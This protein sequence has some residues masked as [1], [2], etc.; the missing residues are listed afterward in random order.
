[1]TRSE[2]DSLRLT[3]LQPQ[4]FQRRRTFEKVSS[5]QGH[6]VT[7]LTKHTLL[8]TP[9]VGSKNLYSMYS[10]EPTSCQVESCGNGT[11]EDDTLS[12]C[13]SEKSFVTSQSHSIADSSDSSVEPNGRLSIEMHETPQA[14]SKDIIQDDLCLERASLAIY[15]GLQH[16]SEDRASTNLYHEEKGSQ[17]PAIR[18]IPGRR[19]AAT[20]IHGLS[21]LTFSSYSQEE[22]FP[23][24][25][26]STAKTSLDSQKRQSLGYPEIDGLPH[27]FDISASTSSLPQE[28]KRCSLLQPY[29]PERHDATYSIAGQTHIQQQFR[30]NLDRGRY[31]QS[32]GSKFWYAIDQQ[33]GQRIFANPITGECHRSLPRGAFVLASEPTGRWWEL[34]DDKSKMLYYYQ[35]LSGKTQW[36]RPD[37]FVVPMIAVQERLRGKKF[38]LSS[39][40]KD[41]IIVSKEAIDMEKEDI[42]VE[43]P[44]T[45]T[46]PKVDRA[47]SPLLAPPDGDF[48]RN[49]RLANGQSNPSMLKQ[50]PQS[51][52]LD[53]FCN[54]KSLKHQ[55]TTPE[56]RSRIDFEVRN[57]STKRS[58]DKSVD[59]YVPYR[60]ER[61]PIKRRMQNSIRTHN[62]GSNPTKTKELSSDRHCL[63]GDPAQKIHSNGEESKISF[64]SLSIIR[65]S[66]RSM[67]F[68][69]YAIQHFTAHKSGMLRKKKS[70]KDMTHWQAHSLSSPLH[71]ILDSETRKDA[72]KCFKIIMRAFGQR[73]ASAFRPKTPPSPFNELDR[74]TAQTSVSAGRQQHKCNLSEP[75]LLEE[76]VWLFERSMFSKALCDELFAQTMKQLNGNTDSKAILRGWMFMAIALTFVAPSH[77]LHICLHDFIE[78][79]HKSHGALLNRHEYTRALEYCQARLAHIQ[80]Y[81]A[82]PRRPLIQIELEEAEKAVFEPQVF[83]HTLE[84]IMCRQKHAYPSTPVPIMFV[85]THSD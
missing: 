38:S 61:D 23:C 13:S 34:F 4:H 26:K 8:E 74:Y 16:H 59:L 45:E 68:K 18:Q 48:R 24:D 39:A 85:S 79:D 43:A 3:L 19:T 20:Q 63:I 10:K 49:H 60:R 7:S 81:G 54:T 36:E 77:A 14:P 37:E 27:T 55:S 64:D 40:D 82:P 1:M 52:G 44:K 56:I 66:P 62:T 41:S 67:S 76:I 28:P 15:S 78:H 42:R 72:V 51:T 31:A 57:A 47:T 58:Y 9:V 50:A 17:T 84:I 22:S 2:E 35:S 75:T 5:R 30:E 69:E 25:G 21:D 6:P 70:V 33:E 71:S 32:W 53:E 80:H 83:G 12:D 65:L 11:E 46:L 29:D 73:Q